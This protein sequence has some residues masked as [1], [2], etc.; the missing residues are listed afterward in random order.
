MNILRISEGFFWLSTN[1]NVGRDS[2]HNLT[3]VLE[4]ENS[5]IIYIISTYGIHSRRVVKRKIM[6]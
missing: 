6:V 1:D 2:H 4:L 5:Y 3:S